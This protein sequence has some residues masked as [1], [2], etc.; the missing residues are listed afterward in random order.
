[1]NKKK[2]TQIETEFSIKFTHM[3]DVTSKQLKDM[4]EQLD[5]KDDGIIVTQVQEV[6][7]KVYY[8]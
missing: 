4:L 3:G 5:T 6:T 8:A 2:V 1:M 7:K